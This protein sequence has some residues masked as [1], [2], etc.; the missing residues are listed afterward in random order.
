MQNPQPQRRPDCPATALT[1]IRPGQRVS[2]AGVS[3]GRN[4]QGRLLSMGLVPG[5]QVSV[6]TNTGQGPLLIALGDSRL[7]IGRGLAG[8]ILVR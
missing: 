7:T 8:K 1:S 2:I 6:I 3:A 5:A 4:V